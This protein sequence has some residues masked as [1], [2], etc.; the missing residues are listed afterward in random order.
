VK[1]S[2]VERIRQNIVMLKQQFLQD[3]GL[4]AQAL[5]VQLI[6]AI[7]NKLVDSYRER[8]YPPAGNLAAVCGSSAIG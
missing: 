5:D 4:F 2:K 6:E 7:V 8:I 3:E 1:D